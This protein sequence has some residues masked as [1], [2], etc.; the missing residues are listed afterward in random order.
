[1]HFRPVDIEITTKMKSVQKHIPFAYSYY[2]K[3]SYDDSLNKFRIY[4]GEDSSKKFFQSLVEDALE[5]YNNYL[6][7]VKPMN[8]LTP[9][10]QQRQNEDKICHI[11]K[12]HLSFEERVADHCHLTGGY[13]GPAHNQCNLEYQ[14]A[15]FIPIFFHNFS[16]Y[17]CLL[18]VKELSAIPGDI[19]IIP[20]NKE[21]YVSVSINLNA[22]NTIELRFLDS[23]RFMPLGLESLAS[24]LDDSDLNVVSSIYN[25]EN[26]FALMRKKGVFPYDY[27]D[28][29]ERLKE[30]QL[31]C[32]SFF[33]NKLTG[34][35]CKTEAYEHAKYG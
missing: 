21:L 22:K 17:D 32:K 11:F 33:F 8:S 29:L 12:N 1:M 2:N 28:S 3:C 24:Y 31:P 16:G 14:I 7:Q 34:K 9:L 15:K 20:L 26:E 35:K 6:S 10:Q 25:N 19:N 5:I 23:F 13:R 18:F 4:S 27:L 30:T